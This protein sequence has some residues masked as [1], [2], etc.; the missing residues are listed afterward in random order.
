MRSGSYDDFISGAASKLYPKSRIRR[1]AARVL[2]GYANAR[3]EPLD[4]A[5]GPPYLRVLGFTGAGRALLADTNPRVPVVTNY[6]MIKKAGSR[7]RNFSMLETA[8]TDIYAAAF[9]NPDFRKAGQDYT[10]NTIVKT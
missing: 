6:K 4:I 1:I 10:R 3:L 9:A 5:E 2:L 8:A 7:A